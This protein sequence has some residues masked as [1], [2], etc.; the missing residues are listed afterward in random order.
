MS[1]APPEIMCCRASRKYAAHGRSP[2][3]K[4]SARQC[5]AAYRH[6]QNQTAT[7]IAPLLQAG[8]RLFGETACKRRK[9]NG[10]HQGAKTSPNA[11]D[12]PA[13]DHVKAAGLFD[14][15]QTLDREK[16]ARKLAELKGESGSPRL[17]IQL[18]GEEPQNRH[19]TLS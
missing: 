18:S 8:H 10:R 6:F 7:E 2:A 15:I 14:V 11:S 9:T 17:L 3:R 16:L 5:G 19:H 13:G 4:R 12:T 1:P